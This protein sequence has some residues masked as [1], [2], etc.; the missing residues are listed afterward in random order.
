MTNTM[1]PPRHHDAPPAAR[2]LGLWLRRSLGI[3]TVAAIAAAAVVTCTLV[4]L[5]IML[6]RPSVYGAQA[7]VLINPRAGQSDAATD[8]A[9]ATQEIILRSVSVLDPVASATGIHASAVLTHSQG[10]SATRSSTARP[11]ASSS[12][13]R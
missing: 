6:S 7:D 12:M 13:T 9:L 11:R 1:L 10:C 8:R 2:L 3:G 4:A 5:P